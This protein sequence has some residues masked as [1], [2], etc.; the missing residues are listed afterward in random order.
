MVVAPQFLRKEMKRSDSF[1]E[2]EKK[3]VRAVAR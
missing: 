1:D 3:Q 2:N